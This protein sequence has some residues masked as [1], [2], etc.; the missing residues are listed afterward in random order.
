MR[1][2]AAAHVAAAVAG[3]ERER[4][5]AVAALSAVLHSASRVGRYTWDVKHGKNVLVADQHNLCADILALMLDCESAK[6][7]LEAERRRNDA[8]HGS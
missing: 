8:P 7:V 1:E 4:D 3:A 6:P 5:E 2:E